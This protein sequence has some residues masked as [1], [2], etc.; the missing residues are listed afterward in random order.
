ME[1][2]MWFVLGLAGEFSLVLIVAML[3]DAWKRSIGKVEV[4]VW[5]KMFGKARDDDG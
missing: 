5:E 2:W 1:G 3:A 4:S